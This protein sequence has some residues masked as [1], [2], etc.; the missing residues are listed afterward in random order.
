LLLSL[1]GDLKIGMIHLFQ[2]FKNLLFFL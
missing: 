1:E 2:T